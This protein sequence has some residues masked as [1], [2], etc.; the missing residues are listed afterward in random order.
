MYSMHKLIMHST[1]IGN[2]HSVSRGI[3]ARAG[4]KCMQ[5]M[6]IIHL[7]KM[8]FESKAQAGIYMVS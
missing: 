1:M 7:S 4:T 3:A 6:A 5:S 2:S 8:N